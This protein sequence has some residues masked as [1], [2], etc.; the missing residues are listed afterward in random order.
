MVL[1]AGYVHVRDGVYRVREVGELELRF[2]ATRLRMERTGFHAKVAIQCNGVTLAYDTFNVDRD[3]DRTRLANSAYTK[4]IGG[5]PSKERPERADYPLVYLSDDLDH[6]C[7]GLGDAYVDQNPVVQ[8]RGA[9]VRKGPDFILAPYI[10]RNGGTICFAPPGYGKSYVLYLMAICLDA[11]LGDHWPTDRTRSLV[12]NLERSPESVEQ[13]LGNVNA[14]LG[15]DRDRPLDVI[16]AR[17][18]TLQDVAMTVQ[19][20]IERGGVGCVFLDSLSRSGSGNLNDND[21]VNA[22]CNLLNGFQVA[23]FALGH[24]PRGD[25]SHLF[26]SQMFDAA[27]DLMVRLNQQE[28]TGGPMGVSLDLIKRNDVGK[29]PLWVGAFEFDELG[30]VRIRRARAG[31]FGELEA[32]QT[33]SMEDRVARYLG[34]SGARSATRIA[35]EL[36]FN[37]SNVSDMLANSDRFTVVRKEGHSVLY[38][39]ALDA[40]D[41]RA[42]PEQHNQP[43]WNKN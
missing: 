21:V 33:M 9:L 36:G 15:L 14:V 26:G 1:S 12:I 4:L 5:R 41:V 38:G 35:E 43:W 2:V 31:E 24:S 27:A 10:L 11:G 23:W 18:R 17:G 39:V 29:Q 3:S 22:Y 6:F 16:N 34:Q 40:Q 28:K 25:D 30:L 42:T 20:H 37:R 19:Q 32:K 7:A 13:R 8:M